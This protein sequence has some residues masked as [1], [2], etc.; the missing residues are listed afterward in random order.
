[1]A[2]KKVVTGEVRLG[3]VH[4]FEPRAIQEGGQLKYSVELIIDKKDKNVLDPINKAVQE[5]IDANP[6]IFKNAKKVKLPLRDGDEDKDSFEYEGK[7]F[8]SAS[9]KNPPVVIDENKV[10]ILSPREIYSGCYGRVSISFFAF[11]KA[12]NKGVGAALNAV[13]KTRDGE[14]LGSTYTKADA[15]SDFEDDNMI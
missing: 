14:P 10:E 2:S 4:L 1:M 11:D 13:Q 8:L 3:F 15:M 7:F 9:D 5:V 6:S 12:G